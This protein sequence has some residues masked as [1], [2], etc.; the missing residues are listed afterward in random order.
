V[1]VEGGGFDVVVGGGQLSV[2]LF[3]GAGRLSELTDV[4]GGTLNVR[5]W[6]VTSVTVSV[7]LDAD[8][9]STAI[10]EPAS[11]AAT[12]VAATISFLRRNTFTT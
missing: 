5:V 10:A 4:P 9:G 7:Q 11:A 1:V 6:P 8:T 2:Q 12:A 3:T